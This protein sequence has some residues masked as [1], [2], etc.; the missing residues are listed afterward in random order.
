MNDLMQLWDQHPVIPLV[1]FMFICYLIG[2]KLK[3]GE[4]APDAAAY[5]TDP[6][7]SPE[8]SYRPAQGGLLSYVLFHWNG[9]YRD[10][11]TIGDLLRSIFCCGGSGSGKTTGSGYFIGSALAK[12]GRKISL[13]IL[14]S[15]PEDPDFWRGI[16]R[17]AGRLRDLLVFNVASGLRFGCLDFMQKNGADTRE[18]TNAIMVISESLDQEQV[19]GRQSEPF[20]RQLK[21][22]ILYHGVDIVKMANGQMSSSDLEQFIHSMPLTPEAINTP[23]FKQSYCYKCMKRAH[24]NIR[25]SIQKHDYEAD[26]NFVIK[27]WC[28][29][30]EKTRSSGLA[31]VMNTLQVLNS[32]VVRSV[33]SGPSNISPEVFDEGMS[34]LVDFPISRDGV[35]GALVLAA[36]KY[37]TQW[38]ILKRQAK[39]ETPICVL[40]MDEYQK[41]A[42]S[43]DPAFLAECRSHRGSMVVLTQSIHALYTRIQQ[44]GEH[45]VDALLTNFYHKVAHALGDEKSASYM[46]SLIGRRLKTRVNVSSGGEDNAYDALYGTPKV[47]ASTSQSIENILEP[48]E[49]MQGLRTGGRAHGY[50][51]DGWVIRSEAFSNGENF[52]RV[53]FSQK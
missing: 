1:V 17:K 20:W 15:K 10:P 3:Q 46:S 13:L 2:R 24:E 9:K 4:A 38:Y 35:S 30:S 18:I 44:A 36:W 53:S 42:S 23:A 27:E 6:S 26:F 48:R 21:Q 49:F 22:R 5:S 11:F 43:F 19:G 32:G 25:T 16:Y 12:F 8:P 41:V 52:L 31:D 51:V 45:G 29:M 39:E 40:W 50:M 33:L 37:L 47:T 34:V 14:A 7:Y 28:S